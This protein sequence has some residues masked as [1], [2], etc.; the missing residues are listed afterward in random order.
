MTRDVAKLRKAAQKCANCEYVGWGVY[1][2]YMELCS[3][4]LYFFESEK[5]REVCIGSKWLLNCN[6]VYLGDTLV[7]VLFQALCITSG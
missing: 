1:I 4:E 7:S 6:Q 2:V 5:G 3:K